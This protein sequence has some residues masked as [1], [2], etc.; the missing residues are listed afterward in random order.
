V[1]VAFGAGYVH[2]MHNSVRC[3]YV[4]W[5]VDRIRSTFPRCDSME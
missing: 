2:D 5:L 3:M 1:Q 4:R